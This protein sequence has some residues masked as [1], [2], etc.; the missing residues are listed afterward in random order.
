[1]TIR[2]PDTFIRRIGC[3]LLQVLMLILPA[4]SGDTP[5]PSREQT[6]DLQ[7]KASVTLKL[8]QVFVTDRNG[9]PVT[10]LRLE[11][12]TLYDNGRKQ[13]I[14]DFE[15]HVPP[16]RRQTSER[17][18]DSS[19]DLPQLN[20]KFFLLLDLAG[21]DDVAVIKAKRSA[22]HFLE[23]QLL[24]TD[25]VAV[26]SF[27]PT[28]GLNL[29]TYLTRDKDKAMD[30]VKNVQ[31]VPPGKTPVGL[32]LA[33][34]RAR[35][36]GAA[37]LGPESSVTEALG[38]SSR[39]REPPLAM[40]IRTA[41]ALPIEVPELAKALN[42][43]PGYK[44]V[45]LFSGG[46][47]RR[48]LPLYERM[49]REL[50]SANCLVYAVNSM[51]Q[52][53][54][55]LGP[56][57][58]GIENLKTLAALSGGAY[59]EDID[60]YESISSEI[61]SA[62]ANYYVLGYTIDNRWDGRYHDIEVKVNRDS[63]LVHAQAGYFNPKPFEQFTDLEK[64]LHLI[65]LALSS[66][67]YHQEPVRFPLQPLTCS[68]SGE[69][70]VILLSGIPVKR[71]QQEMTGRAELL[72]LIYDKDNTLTF[73]TRGEMMFDALSERTL[74]QYSVTA[75]APGDYQCRVVIRDLSSGRAAVGAS[76]LRIPSPS[77]TSLRMDPPLVLL[78]DTNTHFLRLSAEASPGES[79]M[80]LPDFFP[81]LRGQSRPVF[82]DLPG[83]TRILQALIRI[84]TLP[85]SDPDP[86]IDVRIKDRAG[87]RSLP[88]P[89]SILDTLSREDMDY[90]L[91][92]L[93]LPEMDQGLYSL[94]FIA[95]DSVTGRMTSANQPLRIH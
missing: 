6:T 16:P 69:T 49:G 76:A 66:S 48:L 14:T 78:R 89:F 79:S 19:A 35:A 75:L 1:M 86:H 36:E 15:R 46:G 95:R 70:H 74:I 87:S 32:T 28:L 61:H 21:T 92:E 7:H 33:Q 3:A 51:G 62:T 40:K 8:V 10:D 81:F 24:P 54:N 50:A 43:L 72:T 18:S 90:L 64:Q 53:A 29:H 47:Y 80:G 17:A 71:I 73:S 45:I 91:L 77:Q 4:W 82:E 23:T 42:Y 2:K 37:G 65:D 55:F 67:P 20:R 5:I 31:E 85:H 30:A 39:F 52:R 44:H 34:E 60:R 22:L 93:R 26:L 57:F 84:E 9:D 68:R 94:E 63:C 13:T 59:F 56:E 83:G 11:D 12:F 88:I 38:A 27:T 41:V 25:E 58:I